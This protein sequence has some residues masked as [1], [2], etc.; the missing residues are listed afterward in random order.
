MLEFKVNEDS[1]LAGVGIIAATTLLLTLILSI[2]GYN[3]YV[4]YMDHPISKPAMVA[5]K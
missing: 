4:K 2:L 3:V 1:L 5:P